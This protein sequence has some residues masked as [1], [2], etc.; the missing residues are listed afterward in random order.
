MEPSFTWGPRP[1]WPSPDNIHTWRM[2]QKIPGPF[3]SAEQPPPLVIAGQIQW[4]THR[5]PQGLPLLSPQSALTVSVCLCSSAS[6]CLSVYVPLPLTTLA[7][8]LLYYPTLTVRR[9]HLQVNYV[10]LQRS[11]DYYMITGIYYW[12]NCCVYYTSYDYN[13]YNR[14]YQY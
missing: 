2:S 10:R 6:V 13:N 7:K 14:L 12:H 1:H 8:S 11:S 5:Q 9:R 4:P 3:S